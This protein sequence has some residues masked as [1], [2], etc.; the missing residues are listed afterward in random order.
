MQ[1]YAWTEFPLLIL[2]LW[3][4]KCCNLVPTNL[5]SPEE[6]CRE[7]CC[8]TNHPEHTPTLQRWLKFSTTILNYGT[9]TLFPQTWSLLTL[10]RCCIFLKIIKRWSRWSSRAE[11]QAVSEVTRSSQQVAHGST[12]TEIISL[13]AGL[14]MDGIPVLD[15]WDLMKECSILPNTREIKAQGHLSRDTTSNKH[16]QNKSKVPTHHDNFDLNNVDCVPSN[17]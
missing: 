13:D 3:L 11:V 1:V 9:S 8:M 7:V 12:E 4:L 14:G 2:G 6:K 16:T 10:V 5:R 15:L 17:A